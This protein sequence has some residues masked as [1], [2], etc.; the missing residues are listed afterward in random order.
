M[1]MLGLWQTRLMSMEMI[2]Y[3]PQSLE[4]DGATRWWLIVQVTFHPRRTARNSAQFSV[5]FWTRDQTLLLGEVPPKSKHAPDTT[6]APTQDSQ[7]GARLRT[8]SALTKQKQK[9]LLQ[10]E[11]LFLT[12][13]E[14]VFFG[15]VFYL[16]Q[17]RKYLFG[18]LIGLNHRELQPPLC[19]PNREF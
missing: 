17:Q 19:A 8:I 5:S 18:A 9:T 11:S 12:P 3:L 15:S 10:G 13:W 14:S 1:Q 6:P 7:T 16:E 2:N 4:L